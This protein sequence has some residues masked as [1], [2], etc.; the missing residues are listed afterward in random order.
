MATHIKLEHLRLNAFRGATQEVVIPFDPSKR[1]TLIFGENGTGKSTIIDSLTYLC[2]GSFG[3]LADRADAKKYEYLTSISAQPSDVLVELKVDG[4]LIVAR[5]PKAN[6]PHLSTPGKPAISVLRRA[7]LSDFV[8]AIPSKRFEKLKPFLATSNIELAEG[9]LRKETTE[10][11][12]QSFRFQRDLV[13]K[14]DALKKL[15]ESESDKSVA[16]EVWAKQVGSL[17]VA[18]EQ[19]YCDAID[20]IEA[21]IGMVEQQ[22]HEVSAALLSRDADGAKSAEAKVILEK[23]KGES[24]DSGESLLNTLK[25]AQKHLK[26]HGGGEC[27]VCERP[28]D[29]DLLSQSLGARIAALNELDAAVD[30]FAIAEKKLSH[31]N[32][33]LGTQRSTWLK[34]LKELHDGLTVRAPWLGDVSLIKKKLQDL[35]NSQSDFSV[36][37]QEAEQF[38]ADFSAWL[39]PLCTETDQK[40][41][42]INLKNAAQQALDAVSVITQKTTDSELLEKALKSALGIVEEQRKLFIRDAL[43]KVSGDIDLLYSKLHP[44]EPLNTIKLAL[45]EGLQGSLDISANFE[46]KVGV[47]PQAYYSEAHL[48][49]LGICI[50]IAFA[51]KYA[52]QGS[53]IVLDDVLTSVDN[54]HLDRFIDFI[55]DESANF[56]HVVM[57]THYRPWRDRFRFHQAARSNLHFIELKE[58]ALS[59]G[60]LH[61]QTKTTLDELRDALDP[62]KFDRQI[63]ASKA[64]IF[65]ERIYDF[66]TIKYQ[67]KLPR[68]TAGDYTLGEFGG[69]FQ[70]KHLKQLEVELID[71]AT[72]A[73]SPRV[74]LEPLFTAIDQFAWIRNQV[75]CHFNA[76][77]A[78]VGDAD[79]RKFAEAV[80]ALGA[81]LVCP[82]GGD[83]PERDG[84]SFW[85]SKAKVCRL[86]PHKMI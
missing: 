54:V 77:A 20:T 14:R 73:I 37:L 79:V 70:S 78:G 26:D 48:D 15:W 7:T 44:G 18:A 8:E 76:G 32:T 25:S 58:W 83:F 82:A 74:P 85:Q 61:D 12:Q 69:A 41:K 31:A 65:L 84:G 27:P 71:V 1:A 11:E 50:F 16:A 33:V 62:M 57:T 23:A 64:G 67:A 36:I 21:L 29:V 10:V 53:L 22:R 3:S 52:E 46:T 75:G 39:Q 72:G 80:V 28:T 59:R 45:K 56:G 42:R 60:L 47:P 13:G 55:D 34:R 63:V 4:K 40:R 24:R 17:D 30:E 43:Q 86:Y 5:Q 19:A 6:P 2:D 35:M 68:K 51:K 49:T 81:A 66:L 38:E 9:T